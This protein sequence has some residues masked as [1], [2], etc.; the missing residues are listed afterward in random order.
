M[1]TES[2]PCLPSNC[3]NWFVGKLF[4]KGSQL[5]ETQAA[6][7]QRYLRKLLLIV[8][9]RN[10]SLGQKAEM[11]NTPGSWG[12]ENRPWLSGEFMAVL[13]VALGKW[14]EGPH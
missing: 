6:E 10:S 5:S 11:L 2:K 14:G 13:Q 3:A 4:L 8:G 7:P 9:V 1:V 12:M